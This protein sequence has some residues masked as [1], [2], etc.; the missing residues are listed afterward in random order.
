MSHLLATQITVYSDKILVHVYSF[1]QLYRRVHLFLSRE[2]SPFGGGPTYA[3][4]PFFIR[5]LLSTHSR[6]LAFGDIHVAGVAFQNSKDV[7]YKPCRKRMST[8]DPRFFID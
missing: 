7:L 6:R 3:G 2:T 8:T 5:R 4:P 1:P